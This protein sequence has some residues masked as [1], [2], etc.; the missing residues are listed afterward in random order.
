MVDSLNRLVESLRTALATE[1]EARERAEKAFL[2]VC[3]ELGIAA[4]AA[5]YLDA[6][7]IRASLAEAKRLLKAM[8]SNPDKI[9]KDEARRFLA[10]ESNDGR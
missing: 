6:R 3:E 4:T 8:L 9:S 2:R 10:Q 1:R 7:A 5:S